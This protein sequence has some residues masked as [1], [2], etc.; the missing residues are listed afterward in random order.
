MNIKILKKLSQFERDY[1]FGKVLLLAMVLGVLLGLASILFYILLDSVKY[2]ALESLIHYSDMPPSGQSPVFHRESNSTIRWLFFIVPAL[3]GLIS[4][5]IVYRFAPTAEGHGTEAAIAAYHS[6]EG[7]I[8]VRVPLVKAITSSLI[9]GTGGSG[10]KEGPIA[11]IG[12]GIGS[13][14]AEIL[15]L[16][17]RERRVLLMSGVGAGIGAVFHSPLAGA[18]FASE[19]LYREMEFE[20][21]ILVPVIIS[22]VM[23]YS[24]FTIRF[25][26]SSLFTTPV[27]KFV[28][29]LE[30]IPYLILAVG[31][32]CAAFLFVNIFEYT[33]SFFQRLAIPKY[34]RVGLGG[35]LAGVIAYFVPETVATSYQMLQKAFDSLQPSDMWF[36]FLFGFLKMFSTSFTIGSGG[37]AGIFG[38]SIVIGGTIGGGIGLALQHIFGDIIYDPRSYVLVGMAGFF[39][40]AANT[41]LSTVVMVSEITGNYSLL[42]PSIWVCIISF[43]LFRKATVYDS[44]RANHL[45]SPIHTGEFME[46]ILKKLSI[47]DYL[48]SCP[49]EVKFFSPS[50]SLREMI[51]VFTASDQVAFP[52]IDEEGRCLGVVESAVL[53][54]IIRE[55]KSLESIIVAQDIMDH[56]KTVVPSQ[57][58]FEVIKLFI[59]LQLEEVLIVDEERPERMIGIISRRDL[60]DFYDK[61]MSH[62]LQR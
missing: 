28:H 45:D 57:S 5:W 46:D 43:L 15:R 55:E 6:H 1:Y 35:F 26:W 60:V 51:D 18:L 7:R 13:T 49:R 12:A 62:F 14:L 10:G 47:Q 41:P 56:P 59:H 16:S 20:Y 31:I 53:R 33:K 39:S 44:Q 29:P 54:R 4:G 8:P 11:Q 48:Q 22:S 27:M 50:T 17:P 36:L 58:I 3:G 30:L 23:A 34:L 25:H 52:V 24:I 42:V 61:E 2:L 38:P 21:E 32:S 9:I 40:T 19:V 37:S